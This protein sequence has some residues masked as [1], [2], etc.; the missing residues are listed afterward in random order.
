[1]TAQ[2]RWSAAAVAA[3]HAGL[4]VALVS[5]AP[6][7]A[8]AGS[9]ARP[10]LWVRL[11]SDAPAPAPA[12]APVATLVP[13]A[14]PVLAVPMVVLAAAETP[15]A[16]VAP[17]IAPTP[18]S[19]PA[20]EPVRVAVLPQASTERPANVPAAR[21]EPPDHAACAQAPHPPL[22][23]ERGIEGQVQL[24]VQVGADGHAR[25]VQLLQS[26]GWRL[27][28]EAALAQARGCR[29]RPAREG[30][31]PVDAWVE[32]PVRFTLRG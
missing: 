25:Q 23:R 3:A 17:T 1:M 11:L 14:V 18:A 10:P 32:F 21:R 13:P 24:R 8:P 27:F 29:F 20:P 19:P 26:S 7:P 5:A 9:S 15:P 30:D 2:R 16:V 22:L 4:L 31:S 12:P 28:D 6:P